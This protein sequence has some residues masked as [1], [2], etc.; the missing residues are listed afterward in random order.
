M[1]G[2]EF[3]DVMFSMPWYMLDRL[4]NTLVSRL[5][6]SGVELLMESFWNLLNHD[7]KIIQF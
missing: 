6:H 7:K 2:S 4:Y 5:D 1:V 3:R